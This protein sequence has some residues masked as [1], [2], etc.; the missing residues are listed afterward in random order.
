MGTNFY[1]PNWGYQTDANG[2][3]QVRNARV[4]SS[5]VPTIMLTHEFKINDKSSLNTA[6]GFQFGR[7]GNTQ[8]NWFNTLD[9][10]PDYYNKL[11]YLQTDSN[12]ISQLTEAYQTNPNISQINWDNLYEI[13]RSGR[14]TVINGQVLNKARYI[15]ENRLTESKDFTFNTIYNN[16]I[17]DIVD[18]TA[19]LTYQYSN[20]RNY[21]VLADLLGADYHLDINQFAQRAFPNNETVIQNNV[22]EAGKLIR[23]GD[24]FGYDYNMIYHRAGGWIQAKVTLKKVEFFG[25]ARLN[26]SSY[27]RIGNIQSGT[28]PTNSLGKSQTFHFLNPSFKLGITYKINGRN[29]IFANGSYTSRAPY[30]FNV[31]NS[32]RTRNQTIDNVRSEDIYTSEFGYVLNAPRIKAK[33]VGYYSLFLHGIETRS[34]YHDIYQNFVNQ[35][36]TGIDR[37]YAGAELAI[38]GNIYKGFGVTAVTAIGR[39][40]YVSRPDVT[41]TLD[42]SAEK[43]LDNVPAYLKNYY[44]G[45]GPQWANTISLFYN[46][47]KFWFVRL[48]LNYYDRIFV[49]INPIRRTTAAVEGLDMTSDQYKQI[50]AQERLKGQFTMDLFAGYSWRLNSTFKNM[51]GS[52]KFLNFTLSVSNLLNNTRFI[53]SGFEQMRYDFTEKTAARFPNKYFYNYGINFFLNVGFRM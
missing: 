40:Q 4:F 9:P 51:K 3:R 41:I 29:F 7:T 32:P 43:V 23:Q 13:N 24:V 50:I 10:R 28:F 37:R 25:G 47:P 30:D 46:S 35:T 44:I 49:D 33:A 48:N 18:L 17:S 22:A 53:S 14:D 45:A 26:Y 42:N 8:L 1:N 6:V 52:S 12:I 27:W 20:N 21:K 16:A 38:E 39:A 15:L 11:P 5:H 31:F 36:M 34:Y 2:N 19:G